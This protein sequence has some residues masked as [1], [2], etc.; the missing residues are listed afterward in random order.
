MP[1]AESMGKNIGKNIAKNLSGKYSPCM[2]AASEK[3]LDHVKQSA[4]DEFKTASKREIQKTAEATGNLIGNKTTNKITRVL[5]NSQH[6]NSET[7]TNEQDKEI[8]KEKYV[9]PEERQ[10][11]ID[12]MRLK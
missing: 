3:L 6:N 12:E 2:L 5:Q 7:V 10:E 11:I 9:S 8:P 1:F 4:R